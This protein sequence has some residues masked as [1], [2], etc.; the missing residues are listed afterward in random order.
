[1]K[2]TVYQIENR[3]DFKFMNYA[4]IVKSQ[5][6][7]V[8][9]DRAIYNEVFDGIIEAIDLNHVFSLLNIGHRPQGYAGHSLSVSDIVRTPDGLFFVDSIGFKQVEFAKPKIQ[10]SGKDGNVFN[11]MALCK[12]ALE[13]VGMKDEAQKMQERI[14][15][16]KPGDNNHLS[17]YD[18][19]LQIMMEYCEVS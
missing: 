5:E 10:L 17:G 18:Q 4:Y 3:H 11:L 16:L 19:A 15:S 12:V 13:K 7:N 14:T 1:M 6:G 9:M 8:L 2:I